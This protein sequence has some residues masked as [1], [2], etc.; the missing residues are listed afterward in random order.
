M[1]YVIINE[2]GCPMRWQ[3]DNSIVVYASYEAAMEDYKDGDTLVPFDEY[4]GAL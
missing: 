2:D 3:S 4:E 1:E